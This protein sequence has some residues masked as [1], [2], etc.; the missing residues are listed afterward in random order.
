MRIKFSLI[1][2]LLL[3]CC[4]FSQI[5]FAE[6]PQIT[7]LQKV[8][9]SAKLYVPNFVVVGKDT[10]FKVFT[11]PNYHVKLVVDY[12]SNIEKTVLEQDANINGVV[13]FKIKILDDENLVGKSIGVNA[14]CSSSQGTD[15]QTAIMQTENGE[16]AQTNRIEII[17]KDTEKGVYFSPIQSLNHVMMNY[18]FSERS[19]YNPN[20]QIYYDNTPVYVRN[21]RDAQENVRTIPANFNSS[22]R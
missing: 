12:S 14:Y 4:T 18:D 11:K 16:N 13:V 5:S 20:N 1:F 2:I 3:F 19:G 17:D 8:R 22:N 10:T 15:F 21:M 7:A 9:S 6:N